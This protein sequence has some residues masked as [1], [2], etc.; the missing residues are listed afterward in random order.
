M[1]ANHVRASRYGQSNRGG[2]PENAV[3]FRSPGQPANEALSRRADHQRHPELL[4]PMQVIQDREIL[5]ERF[6]KSDSGIKYDLF[7]MKTTAFGF[8]NRLVEVH[9]DLSE[10]VEARLNLL[11]RLR[12]AAHMH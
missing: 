9:F 12:L 11:H 6:P 1:N 4:E 7:S 2:S 8:A 3:A 5:F 10:Y